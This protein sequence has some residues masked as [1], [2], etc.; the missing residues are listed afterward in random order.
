MHILKV[1]VALVLFV[2]SVMYAYVVGVKDG[3][4]TRRRV[5]EYGGETALR[6]EK[7]EFL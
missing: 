6:T 7:Y 2:V 5:E 1:V 3:W 4:E